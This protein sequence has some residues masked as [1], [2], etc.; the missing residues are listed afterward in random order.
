M[1]K[2]SKLI[3][4]SIVFISM[5]IAV[6]LPASADTYTDLRDVTNKLIAEDEDNLSIILNNAARGDTQNQ[7]LAGVINQ[8]GV[9]VKQ[10]YKQAMN[11]YMKAA[12]ERDVKAQY[13]IG[14]LHDNGL[15]VKQDHAVGFEWFKQAADQ[16][17]P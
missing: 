12:F 4:K 17:D 9:A 2:I 1:Q 16:G 10:D 13:L 11:W 14:F 3:T 7:I 8:A 15:G 5:S 6:A